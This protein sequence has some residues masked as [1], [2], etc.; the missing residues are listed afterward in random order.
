MVCRPY[1]QSIN[2]PLL[3]SFRYPNQQPSANP[4]IEDK[5]ALLVEKKSDSDVEFGSYSSN[6]GGDRMVWESKN[7]SSDN[8]SVSDE[9]Y[10]DFVL[11]DNLRKMEAATTGYGFPLMEQDDKNNITRLGRRMRKGVTVATWKQT[12]TKDITNNDE[13]QIYDQLTWREIFHSL[14]ER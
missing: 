13:N 2:L 8:F 5:L 9:E 14:Q 1:K 10:A 7:S 4:S 11:V 12:T 6:E 3:Y